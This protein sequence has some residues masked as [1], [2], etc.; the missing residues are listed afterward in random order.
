MGKVIAEFTMSL[1]GFIADPDDDVGR[2]FKWYVSGDTPLRVAATD[3]P[4]RVSAASAE[5]LQSLWGSIGATVTGR[6]DFDVSRAWG[7]TSPVGEHTFIVTHHV[8]QEW[9]K[10]EYPFTF[11]TD[12]V[13][14]ALRQAQ[15]VA[16]E[17]RVVMSGSK[18]VQ[19]ALNAGLVDEIQIDLAHMLLGS[20][21]RLFENLER[22]TEL[23]STGI[24]EGMG[25][26]HL[27]YRV[28]K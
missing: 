13:E 14:S 28:I 6:R 20:G 12:G 1:D 9:A 25:V 8:P 23:E 16:G 11:V 15:Q 7:G 5:L 24:V 21:I 17:K 3:R 4:F 2:L 27:Q 22:V 26:T 18:V 19:Q 10:P